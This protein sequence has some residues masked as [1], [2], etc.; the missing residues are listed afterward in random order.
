MAMPVVPKEVLEDSRPPHAKNPLPACTRKYAKG[1]QVQVRMSNEEWINGR[2]VDFGSQEI[3]PLYWV[4][5]DGF[6]RAVPKCE[7]ELGLGGDD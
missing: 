2:I 5:V 6:R 4:E 1:Q 3:L 7:F